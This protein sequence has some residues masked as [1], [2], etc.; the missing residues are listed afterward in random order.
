MKIMSDPSDGGSLVITEVYSGFL[1]RTDEGNEISICMR[2]DT[3][4]INVCPKGEHTGNWWRVNMQTGE[5]Y[6]EDT[7]PNLIRNTESV[8]CNAQIPETSEG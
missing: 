6:K 5:F 1:M 4:E 3:F 8:E 7:T 2:D